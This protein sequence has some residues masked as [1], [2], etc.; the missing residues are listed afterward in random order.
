MVEQSSTGSD[1]SDDRTLAT[2]R[3]IEAPRQRVWNAVHRY[4]QSLD[5]LTACVLGSR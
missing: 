3:V 4:E 5:R 1:P 2:S